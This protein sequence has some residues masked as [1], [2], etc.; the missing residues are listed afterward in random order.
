MQYVPHQ[1]KNHH[2]QV[3]LHH[4]IWTISNI[5]QIAQPST[6]YVNFLKERVS[7]I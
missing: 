3:W 4:Q 5:M 2:K 7:P 6:K 1:S